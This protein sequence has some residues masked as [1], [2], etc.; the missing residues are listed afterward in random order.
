MLCLIR[1]R[2]GRQQPL[3]C[4]L[5]ILIPWGRLPAS[6][7]PLLQRLLARWRLPT[8][9]LSVLLLV[10]IV[11]RVLVVPCQWTGTPCSRMLALLQAARQVMGRGNVAVGN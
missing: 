7:Q 2:S 3:V 10:G 6:S 1:R 5:A 8:L 11:A 4:R 9:C